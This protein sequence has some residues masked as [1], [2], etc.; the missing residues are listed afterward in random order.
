MRDTLN[1]QEIRL[2]RR[3]VLLDMGYY[4]VPSETKSSVLQVFSLWTVVS[5]VYALSVIFFVT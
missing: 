4:P 1:R 5:A 3:V 2:F